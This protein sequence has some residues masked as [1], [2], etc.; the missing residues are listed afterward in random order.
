MQ[1]LG[2]MMHCALGPRNFPSEGGVEIPARRSRPYHLD[3][4]SNACIRLSVS[5]Y[6]RVKIKVLS[7]V[8]SLKGQSYYVGCW[9]S[10]QESLVIVAKNPVIDT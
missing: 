3:L 9:S 8:Y 5:I 2:V 4:M 6:F 1:Q 7:G 10:T